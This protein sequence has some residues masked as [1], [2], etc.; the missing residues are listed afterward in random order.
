M[1]IYTAVI[2]LSQPNLFIYY[3]F[4]NINSVRLSDATKMRLMFSCCVLLD[5]AVGLCFDEEQTLV[6]YT[7]SW[8]LFFLH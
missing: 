1:S 4:F 5:A 8:H 2:L 7:A 3:F 6:E